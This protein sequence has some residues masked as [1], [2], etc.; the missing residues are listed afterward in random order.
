MARLRPPRQLKRYV[1]TGVVCYGVELAV[2]LSLPPLGVNNAVT[3]SVSFWL[4]LIASFVAQKL[5]AFEDSR[6]GLV[7][8]GQAGAYCA[9]V[10]FN[11][12][13][14][15]AV[16]ALVPQTFPVVVTRTACLAMTTI[17]NY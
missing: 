2:L 5:F 4:G 17:W 11:Y 8:A 1:V 14:T 6:G 3:V 13:F 16:V 12:L 10:L 9:L 15:L 7:A